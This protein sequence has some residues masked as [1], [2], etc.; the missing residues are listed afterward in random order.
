MGEYSNNLHHFLQ[1]GEIVA[2]KRIRLGLA[3]EV[4]F[5][6]FLSS[7]LILIV[8]GSSLNIR[9]ER[10]LKDKSMLRQ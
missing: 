2:V 4:T 1:T 10:R 8:T 9:K 5:R 6:P 3:K 7:L